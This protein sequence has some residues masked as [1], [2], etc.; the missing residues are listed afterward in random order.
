M[1]SSEDGSPQSAT[2]ATEDYEPQLIHDLLNRNAKWW[3]GLS[4]FLKFVSFAVGSAAVVFSFTSKYTALVLVLVALLAE[5]AS[6]RS[7]AVKSMAKSL[8]RKLDLFDS[9]GWEISKTEYLDLLVRS[10][11]SVKSKARKQIKREPY[12]ASQAPCGPKR[13]LENI[14]ESAWWSKHLSEKL[15]HACVWML[16]TS[17]LVSVVVLVV[18]IDAT[19]QPPAATGAPSDALVSVAKLVIAA[20]GFVLSAGLT[21]LIVGY[22]GAAQKAGQ[23]EKSAEALLKASSISE[24]DAIKVYYEYHLGRANAPFVPSW[25]WNLHRDELNQLWQS[26]RA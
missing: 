22:Y 12:F 11:A 23:S 6:H 10:P 15:W 7:D 5:L 9:L 14:L 25:Y 19:S 21:R 1:I 20:L 13:A 26:R 24:M 16:A 8:R 4:L 18:A 17:L 2:Q 3:W